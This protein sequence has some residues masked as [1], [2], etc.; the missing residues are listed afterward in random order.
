MSLEERLK[1]Q[2]ANIIY[3]AASTAFYHTS[4]SDE[5]EFTHSVKDFYDEA[6]LVLKA[7]QEAGWYEPIPADP[8]HTVTQ[9]MSATED[10]TFTSVLT[11]TG[12]EWYN[13]FERETIR[14]HQNKHKKPFEDFSYPEMLLIAKR[15]AGLT[16]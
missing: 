2:I 14:L 16:E 4:T 10:G 11:M 6:E 1:E 12:Q 13:R 8:P 9:I 3:D 15:A 5:D 7:I